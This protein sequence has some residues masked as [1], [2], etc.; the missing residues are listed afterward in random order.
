MKRVLPI[1]LLT[2]IV[3]GL[4]IRFFYIGEVDSYVEMLKYLK[5]SQ[6]VLNDRSFTGA[7]LSAGNGKIP[8]NSYF[9][10]LY[11]LT[12]LFGMDFIKLQF[13]SLILQVLTS[14]ILYL[15][16][17]KYLTKTATLG[18][19]AFFTSHFIFLEGS[20]AFGPA[21]YS[22][23]MVTL[24]FYFFSRLI[25]DQK[26]N[27]LAPL[28]FT[29]SLAAQAQ[30]PFVI[31]FPLVLLSLIRFKIKIDL[32]NALLALGTFLLMYGPYFF[33]RE[34]EKDIHS[35]K[36]FDSLLVNFS[37]NWSEK[38]FFIKDVTLNYL[39]I[40]RDPY[41]YIQGITW[42]LRG[43][44]CP[45]IDCNSFYP[46]ILTIL[47]LFASVLI[48]MG[49]FNK[50]VKSEF[51]YFVIFNLSIL[52]MASFF[53][54]QVTSFNVGHH[55]YLIVFPFLIALFGLGLDFLIR[56]MK[57][58]DFVILIFLLGFFSS[59]IFYYYSSKRVVHY[60]YKTLK[61]ITHKL[62][63]EFGITK[64]LV[65]KKVD[66]RIKYQGQSWEK[67]THWTFY[68]YMD[69]FYPMTK[70]KLADSSY[71]GCLMILLSDRHPRFKK[72]PTSLEEIKKEFNL[73]DIKV[74]KLIREEVLY[75]AY[76]GPFNIC[77]SRKEL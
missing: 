72:E 65:N 20:H 29:C 21:I 67:K 6:N 69:H 61:N 68:S 52:L 73:G 13:V 51:F 39:G 71:E 60:R 77:E 18:S 35:S 50:K 66:M 26:R 30:F 23:F 55:R 46:S 2:V 45:L 19:V 42:H 74:D 59:H 27:Y 3:I 25:I 12:S 56:L 75:L 53:I 33:F 14:L 44:V 9:Y 64:D 28:I 16:L 8:G 15:T 48:I 17:K 38:L 10:Y 34:S 62:K 36:L 24:S 57:K 22:I 32:K 1:F 63:S 11:F 7:D 31:F 76:K 5:E 40:I 4:S 41:S 58:G 47:S 54:L 70:T 43:S 49:L 37:S